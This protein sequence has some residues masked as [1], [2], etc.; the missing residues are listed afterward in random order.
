MKSPPCRAQSSQPVSNHAGWRLLVAW[1]VLLGLLWPSLGPWQWIARHAAPAHSGVRHHADAD[2][3]GRGDLHH[4][5]ADSSDIPGSPM[6]PADHNC[7]EC[8][9]LM[10]LTHSIVPVVGPGIILAVL[11]QL[12]P[13]TA[14]APAPCAQRCTAL[15]PIRAPPLPS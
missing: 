12:R 10:H 5:H 11:A 15:P 9:V 6:H 3:G 4:H 8:Q 13:E 7:L 2:S 1:T 14:A